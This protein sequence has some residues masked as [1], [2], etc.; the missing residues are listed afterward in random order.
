LYQVFANNS[1][2]TTKPACTRNAKKTRLTSR[3]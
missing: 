3:H 1:L 2:I